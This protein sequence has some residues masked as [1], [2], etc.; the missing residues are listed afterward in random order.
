[1]L[2]VVI[3]V[4]FFFFLFFFKFWAFSHTNALK[5]KKNIFK[6]TLM[7]SYDILHFV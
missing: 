2:V 5:K 1:M 4:V 7:V 6:P 3:Y